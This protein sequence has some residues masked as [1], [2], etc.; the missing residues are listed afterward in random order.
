MIRRP[1]S[2][3]RT[4]TRLPYTTLFR[5]QG[6]IALHRRCE[7]TRGSRPDLVQRLCRALERDLLMLKDRSARRPRLQHRLG[8]TRG[9]LDRAGIVA[10]LAAI[11]RDRSEEHTSEL[12]SLMRHS[13]ALFCLK[14]KTTNNREH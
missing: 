9:P 7:V 11:G 4:D 6:W 2:V 3:T 13:Y 8:R 10:A 1:P 12:Q 14:Q 5:S